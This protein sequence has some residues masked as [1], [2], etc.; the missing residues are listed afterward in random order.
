MVPGWVYALFG[1][2]GGAASTVGGSWISSKIHVYHENRRA[3]L[4]ELKDKVLIPLREGLSKH[5]APLV[6]NLAPILL[7]QQAAT[8]F[9]E[10]AKVTQ[11]PTE[12]G[13]VLSAA[14]PMT[15]VF[16]PL[17][18]ALLQDARTNHFRDLLARV[19]Q[20][21]MSWSAHAA[22]NHRW[23]SKISRHILA[24]SGL[25]AFPNRAPAP[26]QRFYVMHKRLA[27][28]V[29]DRLS[30]RPVGALEVS[31]QYGSDI[32]LLTGADTTLAM[33]TKTQIDSLVEELDKLLDSEKPAVNKLA[34]KG[35]ELQTA[36][37][38]LISR[39]DLAAASRRLH[40][41]CD[42]VGFF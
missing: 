38:E 17:D 27:V 9:F 23:G 42:L 10:E 32:W 6:S 22:D 36:F 37:L 16:G 20:F 34:N 33:G 29:Y 11:E 3:H 28:F 1:W 24:N 8:E 41:K 31:K 5:Y 12:Q 21:I 25:D 35:A 7:V 40:R 19:D 18:A 30:R 14:S 15:S 26:S 4:E 13:E 39:L 2:V